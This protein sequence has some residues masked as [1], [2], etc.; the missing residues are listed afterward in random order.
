[1]ST[2]RNRV[3]P[4]ARGGPGNSDPK[5]IA[6]QVKVRA[7]VRRNQRKVDSQGWK[8]T[9]RRHYGIRLIRSSVG[10]MVYILEE[11][12]Y[13]RTID[14]VLTISTEIEH[15]DTVTPGDLLRS[16]SKRRDD[17]LYRLI[18]SAAHVANWVE[19]C[20]VYQNKD[21]ERRARKRGVGRDTI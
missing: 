19:Q 14:G 3:R 1:M 11:V 12:T 16:R 13:M 4:P 20:L 15:A 7:K 6:P 2:G 5:D 21:L 17:A 9:G 18:E 8:E 10:A